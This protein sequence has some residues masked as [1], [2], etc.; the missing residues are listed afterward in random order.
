[1]LQT[2]AACTMSA[3]ESAP[4]R[5]CRRQQTGKAGNRRDDRSALVHQGAKI[6]VMRFL[7]QAA[8]S[9]VV[10][11]LRWHGLSS[12]PRSCC[13]S[14]NTAEHLRYGGAAMVEPLLQHM[15]LTMIVAPQVG[16]TIKVDTSKSEYIGRASS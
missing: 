5:C 8:H 10:I 16:E 6:P 3:A 1:M 2:K 7:T 14:L 11:W 12:C 15:R 13:A 9:T 4:E